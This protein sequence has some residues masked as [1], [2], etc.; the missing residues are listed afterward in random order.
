MVYS[1][2][3]RCSCREDESG[4][5]RLRGMGYDVEGFGI[6]CPGG[7]WTFPRLEHAWRSRSTNLL[8]PMPLLKIGCI[9]R[10]FDLQAV[11]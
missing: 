5:S 10:R 4:I 11:R 3:L 9:Q 1:G 7:W 2:F 8:S 6:P